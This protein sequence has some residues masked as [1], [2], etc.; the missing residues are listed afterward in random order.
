MSAELKQLF[1]SPEE[2]SD[3]ELDVLRI[4]L[5]NMRRVPKFGAAFGICGA[6]AFESV[7]L[8]RSPT[9]LM[10]GLGAAAGYAFGGYGASTITSS[11]LTRQFDYDILIA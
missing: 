7:V 6:A 4:K 10:L 11:M 5:Q 8:K 2:L 1:H 9:A 3:S